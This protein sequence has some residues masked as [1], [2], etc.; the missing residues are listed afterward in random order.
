MVF[1]VFFFF[2]TCD[3]R[4]AAQRHGQLF[5]KAH[6]KPAH[7]QGEVILRTVGADGLLDLCEGDDIDVQPP[8]PGGQ[9][10]GQFQHLFPGLLRGIGG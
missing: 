5:G 7:D 8:A 3:Q 6:H 1:D 2:F 4:L 10:L 9:E